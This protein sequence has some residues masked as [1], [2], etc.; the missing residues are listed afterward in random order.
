M[1]ASQKQNQSCVLESII[2]RQFHAIGWKHICVAL[3][4]VVLNPSSTEAFIQL[5]E[6][7]SL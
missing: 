3:D 5:C 4:L 7:H 6:S 2:K 1:G